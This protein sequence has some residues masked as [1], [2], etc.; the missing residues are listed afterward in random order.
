MALTFGLYGAESEDD[1]QLAEEGDGGGGVGWR[2]GYIYLNV[3]G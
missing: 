3:L 2:E 1:L